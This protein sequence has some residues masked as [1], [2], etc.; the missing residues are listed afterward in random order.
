ML[1]MHERM[2]L[3]YARMMVGLKRGLSGLGKNATSIHQF[4]LNRSRYTR[5]GLP[6]NTLKTLDP[7]ER[8]PY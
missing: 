7:Q 5:G 6:A 4:L 2:S 8:L 1:E 3:Q